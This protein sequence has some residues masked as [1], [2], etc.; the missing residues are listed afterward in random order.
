MKLCIITPAVVKGDGQG[1]AN[2]EIVQ[3]AIRRGHHI[4]LVAHRVAEDLIQSPQ[5]EWIHFSIPNLPTALL[6]EVYF[7]WCSARWLKKHRTEFDL[8]QSYGTAT[9]GRSDVNTAQFVHTSWLNSP[10][11]LSKY[12]KKPYASYYWLHSVLNASWE[13]TAFNDAR[14]VIAVS[15]GIRGELRD[16]GVPDDRIHVI[17]NGVDIQ[18]F[19]PE[20]IDRTSLGLPLNKTLAL[21]AGDIKS[22]RKNLDTVL[23]SLV[24]ITDLDLVVVGRLEGSPYPALAEELGVRDRVH[25]LG[26]RTDL[27]NIM[28]GTDLFVFLSRYEPFGMVIAEAMAS[29]LPVITS[30]STGA[31]EIVTPDSG[32]VVQDP[33]DVVALTTALRTLMDD[34]ILRQSMG[35]AGRA[36]VQ[37]HDWKGKAKQYLTLFESMIVEPA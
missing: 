6:K 10:V 12:A 37:S 30:A 11:H 8:V 4:T 14:A 31:S 9:F 13:R 2:Y 29:G 28:R 25:F 23:R 34:R 27:A 26:F 36:I 35:E 15:E 1:R 22:N 19:T 17:L 18:E 7:A 33:E 21:F 24:H 5:V 16:L 32:I 20:P 3:E